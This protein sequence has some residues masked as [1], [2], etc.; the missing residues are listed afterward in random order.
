M[1]IWVV[2]GNCN[3]VAGR[4]C[5]SVSGFQISFLKWRDQLFATSSPKETRYSFKR[6]LSVNTCAEIRYRCFMSY[7]NI[8][9]L[10]IVTCSDPCLSSLAFFHTTCSQ[11][12]TVCLQS[13]VFFKW[14][15]RLLEKDWFLPVSFNKYLKESLLFYFQC[16]F[17]S[18]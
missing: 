17:I 14:M 6:S 4:A 15:V 12:F 18:V 13:V 2:D 1:A 5:L 8:I 7:S 16:Y 11:E 9:L 3:N 10:F